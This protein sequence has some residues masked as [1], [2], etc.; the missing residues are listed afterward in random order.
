[1]WFDI[2][3]PDLWNFQS[4]SSSGIFATKPWCETSPAS[5]CSF[6]SSFSDKMRVSASGFI[7]IF[8][9]GS[10]Q[11]YLQ[12]SARL[13]LRPFLECLLERQ[14]AVWGPA[15][16]LRGGVI[17]KPPTLVMTISPCVPS[18][19]HYKRYLG[20]WS[21]LYLFSW[22]VLGSTV[23]PFKQHLSAVWVELWYR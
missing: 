22:Q 3:I 16:T 17:G 9:V 10:L 15:V 21:M 8:K 12:G 6:E 5:H 4:K 23:L 20:C 11:T 18:V 2:E 1:M 14:E 13:W 7:V 19:F